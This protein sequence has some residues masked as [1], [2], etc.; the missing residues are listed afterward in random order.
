MRKNGLHRARVRLQDLRK[1]RNTAGERLHHRIHSRRLFCGRRG[2]TSLEDS[3][4]AVAILDRL[5]HHATMLQ[6][7]GESYRM[8]GHRAR[9]AQVCA[10]LN[11]GGEFS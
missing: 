1:L 8:R 10:G 5:L 9:I 4:V 2:K 3:T 11:Q 6:I 7:D